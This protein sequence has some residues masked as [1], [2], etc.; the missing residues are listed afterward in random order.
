MFVQR[1]VGKFETQGRCQ[2]CL[3]AVGCFLLSPRV[4][5]HKEACSQTVCA[6]IPAADKAS[7]P[8]D[9]HLLWLFRQRICS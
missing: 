1:D 2:V 8:T 9:L 3:T 6:V 7:D 4:C 5:V